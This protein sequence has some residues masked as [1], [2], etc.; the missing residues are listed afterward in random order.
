MDTSLVY[1]INKMDFTIRNTLNRS[2]G[3]ARRQRSTP[4]ASSTSRWS[5]TSPACKQY[6]VGL[7]SPLNVAAGIEARK[8]FYEIFAGEPDSYRNGGVLLERRADRVGL[9]GVPRLPPG[10]RSGRRP[11]SASASISISKPT[12]PMRCSFP[13]P[14]AARS[15]S[16]FGETVTGKLAARYDFN[17]MFA[18]RGSVQN[19]FRAP[20]L[21]QQF[22]TTTSTNFINGVPFDVTTFPVTDPVAIALGAQPLDAEESINYS[23]GARHPLRRTQRDGRRLPYRHRQPHRAVGKP[24][25]QRRTCVATSCRVRASSA[26]AAGRFFINGVDTETQGVD[27]VANYALR[28]TSLRRFRSHLRR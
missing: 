20:S 27:L 14:S 10:Q 21:Q 24:R 9:A 17:D 8:E 4:A 13:A 28:P 26:R 16:D 23:L 25:S 11:H 12:S 5:P 7:A 15:Y 18:L 22:F 1:G 19:G 3:P 2:L 6:E